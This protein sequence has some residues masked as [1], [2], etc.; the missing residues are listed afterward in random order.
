VAKPGA[1]KGKLGKRVKIVRELI[2][3]VTGYAP[4]EKRVMELLKVGK[5]KVRRGFPSAEENAAPAVF[6]PLQACSPNFLQ[7][8]LKVAKRKVSL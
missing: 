7:R 1:G 2:R 8:A 6:A 3:E 4:Y 5:D